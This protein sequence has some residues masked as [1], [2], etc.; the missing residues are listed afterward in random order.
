M[1]E[2]K[3][4]NVRGGGGRGG[5]SLESIGIKLQRNMLEIKGL[6]LASDG[7]GVDYDKIK[8]SPEFSN[9]TQLACS[10]TQTD[11]KIASEEERKSFFISEWY[12]YSC[13]GGAWGNLKENKISTTGEATPTKI[14]LHAFHINLY[15][16]EFFE[17]ILFFDPHGL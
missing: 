8:D 7:K 6:Y 9:Y 14:G 17:L 10:L 11:L 2:R 1:S 3:I 13:K 4:L 16:Y 12:I 15:L 5:E